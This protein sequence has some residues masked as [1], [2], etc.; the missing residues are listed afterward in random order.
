MN[1]YN[2]YT[3]HIQRGNG[4][5]KKVSKFLSLMMAVV[6]TVISFHATDL[7]VGSVK[8]KGENYLDPVKLSYNVGYQT[9]DSRGY[10]VWY[11]FSLPE[12]GDL[13]VTILGNDARLEK[14][15]GGIEKVGTYTWISAL[16]NISANSPY[17][18]HFSASA[19]T[20]YLQM[21]CAYG[22]SFKIN[23][24]FSGYGY[25]EKVADSYD[26]PK[27]YA[28]NTEITDVVSY[29]DEY[30]W[31]KFVIPENGKYKIYFAAN[32]GSFTVDILDSDLNRY[33]FDTC[34]NKGQMRNDTKYFTQGTYYIKIK[35]WAYSN[36]KFSITKQVIAP[37]VIKKAKSV[38]KGSADIKFKSIDNVEGYQIRYSTNKNFTGKVKTKTFNKG[39]KTSKYVTATIKKLKRH[40]N[41]YFQVRTFEKSSL[42]D[43]FY[44]DWSKVKKVRIK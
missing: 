44:S 25:G 6:L 42:G 11:S 22:E 14:F 12:D 34:I 29:T 24:E 33:W 31:Y 2:K 3:K 30:D 7:S 21:G 4:E 20:Y 16:E 18:A 35:G 37:S 26:N 38:K 13:K 43:Y 9:F 40:K 41:Y 17:V 27:S 36:Y 19:G 10:D 39:Y 23:I 5:M 8:A 28:L 15:Y 32:T 1:M